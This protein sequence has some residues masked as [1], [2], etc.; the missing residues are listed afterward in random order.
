[1]ELK[2]QIIAEL[3]KVENEHLLASFLD[4]I[5]T[6]VSEVPVPMTEAMKVRVKKGEHQFQTGQFVSEEEFESEIDQWLASK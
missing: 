5:R 6:R 2:Q 3:D 1:M 4:W